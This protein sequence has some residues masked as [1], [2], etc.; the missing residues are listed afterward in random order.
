M[1]YGSG[2]L[3]VLDP[4]SGA[5]AGK[6]VLPAH[7]E[8]FQ[9]DPGAGRTF[10]NVPDAGQVAVVDL[11]DGKQVAAWRVPGARGNF[12]MALDGTGALLAA[13]FRSPPRLVLL[14]TPRYAIPPLPDA[15]TPRARL[16]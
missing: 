12:P 11:A 8:G 9:L 4:A 7:P 2:G 3:A 1:G 14:D 15:P 13:V 6:V 5:V 16:P 10:V